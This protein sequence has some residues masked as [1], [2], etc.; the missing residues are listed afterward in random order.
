LRLSS[1]RPW[2]RVCAA[3]CVRA[4]GHIVLCVCCGPDA[5]SWELYLSRSLAALVIGLTGVG[6]TIS[7]A[8][9]CSADVAVFKVQGRRL[10]LAAGVCVGGGLFAA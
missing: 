3:C 7:A 2:L 4:R 6:V 8:S 10:L 1:A 5:R 9:A